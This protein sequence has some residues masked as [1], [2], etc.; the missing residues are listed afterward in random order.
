MGARGGGHCC[1][2]HDTNTT[3]LHMPQQQRRWPCG[4]QEPRSHGGWSLVGCLQHL[5]RPLPHPGLAPRVHLQH[6]RSPCGPSTRLP[7]GQPSLVKWSYHTGNTLPHLNTKRATSSQ[8]P[9]VV[10]LQHSNIAATTVKNADVQCSSERFQ[11]QLS[12]RCVPVPKEKGYKRTS[13]FKCLA[14]FRAGVHCHA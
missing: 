10:S 13:N 5:S 1:L 14:G 11:P 9:G 7:R 12:R 4:H 3:T 6:G 2:P 8:F